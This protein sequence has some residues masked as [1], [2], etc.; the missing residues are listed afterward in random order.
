[1]SLP[2]IPF[3]QQDRGLF[4]LVESCRVMINVL[5]SLSLC[6]ERMVAREW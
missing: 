5:S 6:V 4:R 3:F 1:M 2:L